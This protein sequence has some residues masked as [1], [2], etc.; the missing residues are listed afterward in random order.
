MYFSDTVIAVVVIGYVILRERSEALHT[1]LSFRTPLRGE[2]SFQY[3]CAKRSEES[4]FK[5]LRVAQDDKYA[6]VVKRRPHS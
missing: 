3:Y 2:E 1:S 5:I 4:I 6:I